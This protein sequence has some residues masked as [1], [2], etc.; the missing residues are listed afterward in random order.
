MPSHRYQ[1]LL[2]LLQKLTLS[3]SHSFDHL[4]QVASYAQQLAEIY[5]A[6]QEVV[7]AAALVHD[8]GR[9]HTHLKGKA[10]AEAAV[11]PAQ[12]LLQEA[13][14][15]AQEIELISQCIAE[16]DQPEFQSELLESRILKEADFLDG[17]GARGLLRSLIYAG[18]TGGGVPEAIDRLK[19][20]LRTRLNNLSF[21]AARRMGWKLYRFTEIFLSELEI[22]YQLNNF[23]YP[24]NFIAF[25]GISGSGKDTQAD[26]LAE[27]FNQQ[28]TPHLRVN[29]PSSEFKKQIWPAWR[30]LSASQP[31][32]VAEGLMIMADRHRLLRDQ[33]QAALQEGKIVISTRSSMSLAV[34]QA[35]AEVSAAWYRYFFAFEPV[36]DILIYLD[37]SPDLAYGRTGQRVD[38]KSEKDRGFFGKNQATYHRRY[39]EALQA[40]LNVITISADQS[41]QNVHEQVVAC[42]TERL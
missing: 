33:I 21:P 14:Y 34:Y 13:G 15:S 36:A 37:A 32:S 17:F 18:E 2:K 4:E 26:L 23:V 22:T 38:Q 19:H 41:I 8:L 3:P 27:Y 6:D 1:T 24:G 42:V 9:T 29:H 16:H 39:Q 12:A 10:S 20:K 31:D 40:Y 5:D 35:A 11:E 25:E 28:N 30:E 7:A